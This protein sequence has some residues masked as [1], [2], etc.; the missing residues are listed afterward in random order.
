MNLDIPILERSKITRKN[1]IKDG[2]FNN[3]E[4]FDTSI[5]LN[6]FKQKDSMMQQTL[7]SPI[8][9]I[10]KL[11]FF[12]DDELSSLPSSTIINS[13]Y[14]DENPKLK[15][16]ISNSI[17]NTIDFKDIIHQV[18][19]RNEFTEDD[20]EDI[21]S[22]GDQDEADD[23]EDED[24]D[25][26]ESPLSD[27]ANDSLLPSPP[28]SP[29]RDLDP[30]KLY[31]LFDF[32]GPEDSH[33]ELTKDD[34]VELLNDSDSYWWLVRKLNGLNAVGFAPAEILETY[35]ERLARL[36]CWKNEAIERDLTYLS[37]EDIKEFEKNAKSRFSNITN[38]LTNLKNRHSISIITDDNNITSN[39]SNSN[40][41]ENVY[42]NITLTDRSIN[43]SSSLILNNS[44]STTSLIRKSSLKKSLNTKTKKKVKFKPESFENIREIS[45]Y[46]LHSNIQDDNDG[47]DDNDDDDDDDDQRSEVLS[48]IVAPSSLI[49]SKKSNK[50]LFMIKNIDDYI[51]E[52]E[53]DKESIK[54]VDE[55][56]DEEDEEFD[57][58]DSDK[59]NQHNDNDTA[60]NNNSTITGS[61]FINTLYQD[62]YY[63]NDDQ[64]DQSNSQSDKYS[65]IIQR[66]LTPFIA[67]NANFMKTNDSIGTYSPDSSDFSPQPSSQESTPNMNNFNDH[68][69]YQQNPL[70]AINDNDT[71]TTNNRNSFQ[72][73][74]EK[75]LRQKQEKL[76]KLENKKSNIPLSNKTFDI[77]SSMKLLDDII[78][79]GN[80]FHINSVTDINNNDQDIDVNEDKKNSNEETSNKLDYNFVSISTDKLLDQSIVPDEIE[81]SIP[82]ND[83]I[84][85]IGKIDDEEEEE[86][87][88]EDSPYNVT[89]YTESSL[90][91]YYNKSNNAINNNTS[92]ITTTTT[93]SN[94]GIANG[95]NSVEFNSD[96]DKDDDDEHSDDDDDNSDDDETQ[97]IRNS[98]NPSSNSNLNSPETKVTAI[99][100]ITTVT[101]S[102]NSS[103]TPLKKLIPGSI[104]S[105]SSIGLNT[106]HSTLSATSL[107]SPSS[108]VSQAY[109][110]SRES[111]LEDNKMDNKNTKI[112]QNN[113][114]VNDIDDDDGGCCSTDGDVTNQSLS[115]TNTS[116]MNLHRPV[117]PITSEL[118]DPLFSQLTELEQMFK[119]ISFH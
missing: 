96:V 57:D 45:N 74:R 25:E 97:V 50:K 103:P 1:L 71:T 55:D 22:M 42:S 37:A 105:S 27:Y 65:N 34:P 35:E 20:Q 119:E 108:Q 85:S 4:I 91:D 43:G 115:T 111:E 90:F 8:E 80:D 83:S 3:D 75:F 109:M 60:N 84:K 81:D 76:K 6:D 24:D 106:M 113:D 52:E 79:T 48:D 102:S 86:E 47:N 66:E 94:K 41:N 13:Q 101:T 116:S 15:A 70:N 89:N 95:G 12:N 67:P 30:G 16:N 51:E 44:S 19:D 62:E 18:S 46:S 40:N 33:L 39:N 92:A 32:S 68:D 77:A 17:N 31:A 61:K 29:P 58:Y 114:D 104:I 117:H 98:T 64:Y 10:N 88:E 56:E 28:S 118:F 78:N 5:T 9:T 87:E 11:E 99:N 54:D 73:R 49:V 93:T 112:F 26:L 82:N 110:D 38:S 59:T 36:N 23:D 107:I 69:E 63:S 100:P 7:S 21:R 2:N 14:K 53:E 72:K